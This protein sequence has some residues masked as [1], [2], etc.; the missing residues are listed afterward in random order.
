MMAELA[1]RLKNIVR[2]GTVT[3]SRSAE[4]KALARVLIG[5]RVSDYLP[6][7]GF[8]NAFKTH[9]VP[10][11]PGEQV[12]VFSP[13]GEADSGVIVRGIFNRGRKEPT[14]ANEHTEVIEYEDGTRITYDTQ[15]HALTVSCVGS[16][17]V[18]AQSVSVSAASVTVES[19]AIGLGSG[20]AGV[21]TGESVC[22]FTGAPHSDASAVVKA[23]K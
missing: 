21:I 22:P 14:G 4:G 16:V 7:A 15:A 12:L 20:G 9:W 8:A 23:A 5:E 6:V 13:F 18:Q 1:R 11:R 10:I 19:G 2:V 3:A 17:S